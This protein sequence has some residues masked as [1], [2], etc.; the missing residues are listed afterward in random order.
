M[1][2]CDASRA[3]KITQNGTFL[4]KI[5]FR[6]FQ[7]F[8]GFHFLTIFQKSAQEES[9]NSENLS[10]LEDFRNDEVFGNRF[11]FQ[12]GEF[13]RRKLLDLGTNAEHLNNIRY[14]FYKKKK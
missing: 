13:F 12:N 4:L 1:Q 5:Y 7:K 11:L 10:F 14:F 8:D 3:R 6:N 9:L 2:K